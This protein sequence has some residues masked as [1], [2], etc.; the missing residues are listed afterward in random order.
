MSVSSLAHRT[1]RNGLYPMAAVCGLLMGA[2]LLAGAWGHFTATWPAL[3]GAA[4]PELSARLALLTPGVILLVSGLV[5]VVVCSVLW[6]GKRWA[7]LMALA[8]NLIAV[9][10]FAYLFSRGVPGHPI[11]LFL[12]FTTSYFALLTAIQLGLTWSAQGASS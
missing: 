11:G 1:P 4:Q 10:Y 2:L 8:A 5:N 3:S 6:Q 9:G 7:L 12:G